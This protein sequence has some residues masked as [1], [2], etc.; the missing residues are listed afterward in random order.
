MG[1]YEKMDGV[2]SLTNSDG[3]STI[4]PFGFTN[5]PYSIPMMG[6]SHF[7]IAS[8]SKLYTTVAIYQLY[9][10]GKLDVAADITTML[11][12][13][14]F[15]AFGLHRYMARTYCP[16]LGHGIRRRKCQKLT[17]QHL[18]SMSSG[19]YPPLNCDA[20]PTSRTSC[21]PDP[22]FIN[23]GSI[24]KTI[25]TFLTQPLMFPPGTQYHYSNPN[26]ILAAYFVEKYSGM[27]FRDYLETH[28]FSRMGLN[29]TYYDYFNQALVMDSKRVGQY[30]RY[31]NN[32]TNELMAVGADV[33]QLDLGI[34]SGTGGVISTVADNARF[35]ALILPILPNSYFDPIYINGHWSYRST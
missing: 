1:P 3:N 33:L 5:I 21:N 22:Y 12:A 6:D 16:H 18:L 28:I 20:D 29:D 14:D 23:R 10:Q 9:E 2:W 24:G 15:E 19:I 8:N 34:A 7:P 13:E 25:G 4:A 30:V 11:D 31:Y 17:L 32:C 27:T 26:F 35:P